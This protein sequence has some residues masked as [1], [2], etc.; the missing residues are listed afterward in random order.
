MQTGYVVRKYTR[1]YIRPHKK[2]PCYVHK[3][4]KLVQY[5][6]KF[7]S[8]LALTTHFLPDFNTSIKPLE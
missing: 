1:K 7:D 2:R 8:M 5:G 6:L 3:G 4:S